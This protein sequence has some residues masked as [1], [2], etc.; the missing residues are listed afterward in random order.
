MIINDINK[1]QQKIDIKNKIEYINLFKKL[2]KEKVISE[3]SLIDMQYPL[4]SNRKL[5]LQSN[6]K[7]KRLISFDTFN[8][9]EYI[10]FLSDLT[11][12][13]KEKL[14]DLDLNLG[15]GIFLNNKKINRDN[16]QFSSLEEE[17]FTIEFLVNDQDIYDENFLQKISKKIIDS[18]NDT[19][20]KMKENIFLAK[21]INLNRIKKSSYKKISKLYLFKKDALEDFIKKY[22]NSI[23]SEYSN[24][25][26]DNREEFNPFKE[27]ENSLIFLLVNKVSKS[28]NSLFKIFIRPDYDTLEKNCQL[29]DIKIDEKEKIKLIYS[30][31][32]I[33]IEINLSNFFV[34]LFE[35]FSSCESSNSCEMKEIYNLFKQ[36]GIKVM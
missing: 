11:I 8:R 1:Y 28:I 27:D 23:I 31:R 35:E 29:N 14:I 24:L 4:T 18:I 7:S 12:W 9:D 33:N 21:K 13:L 32:S 6:P 15:Q 22:G 34:Y 5:Y 26:V 2:F 17:Y 20:D 3:F 10:Y 25:Y 36:K 19:I 30:K 16:F